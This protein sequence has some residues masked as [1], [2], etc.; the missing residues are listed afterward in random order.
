MRCVLIVVVSISVL[1]VQPFPISDAA[2]EDVPFFA[3]PN[4]DLVNAHWEVVP[5][6]NLQGSPCERAISH[7]W[8]CVDDSF[9]L[10]DT[11]GWEP[12]HDG[13]RSYV[14]S[15]S[16]SPSANR[17]LNATPLWVDWFTLGYYPYPSYGTDLEYSLVNFTA[18][19]VARR[20]DT[21]VPGT[22]S[23]SI[24]FQIWELGFTQEAIQLCYESAE[25]ISSLLGDGGLNVEWRTYT[26]DFTSASPDVC[27]DGVTR[28]VDIVR[29]GRATMR[30]IYIYPFGTTSP[31]ARISI[32]QIGL[33]G[34]F[35]ETVPD[36]LPVVVPID[37]GMPWLDEFIGFG[38]FCGI[39]VAIF[40]T[41]LYTFRRMKV[42]Q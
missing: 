40:V 7:T 35:R 13:N 21:W 1:L 10:N 41:F 28:L 14:W 12:D 2:T 18:F 31:F 22:F 26:V 3:S 9:A 30:I 24:A 16:N 17:R 11:G 15:Y 33:V 19:V 29:D 37:D 25:I 39:G 20:N 42:H 5:P 27:T 38:M 23:G 4:H 36:D 32:T 6:D 34:W 8:N